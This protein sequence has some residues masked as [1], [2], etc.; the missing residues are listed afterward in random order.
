MYSWGDNSHGQLGLSDTTNRLRPEQIKS[1]RSIGASKVGAGRN[2][3]MVISHAGL[4][5]AF[6]SNNHGQCGLDSEV[7]IQPQPVVVER[8]REL[9]SMDVCCGFAHTFVLCEVATHIVKRVYVMGLNSS[10]QVNST[11]QSFSFLLISY[12]LFLFF[13]VVS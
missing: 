13:S 12:T 3:S 7:K 8:L 9:R 11:L 2:H 6:G 4:L 1:L 5:L 10:G